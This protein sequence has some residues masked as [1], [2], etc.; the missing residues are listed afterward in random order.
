MI[1]AKLLLREKCFHL[2]PLLVS[3]GNIILFF[4]YPN[5][6]HKNC[7]TERTAVLVKTTMLSTTSKKGQ[8]EMLDLSLWGSIIHRR[9]AKKRGGSGEKRKMNHN[10]LLMSSSLLWETQIWAVMPQQGIFV[11]SSS[12]IWLIY[13]WDRDIVY[14]HTHYSTKLAVIPS[15][16]MGPGNIA[17]NATKK[18]THPFVWAPAHTCHLPGLVIII[19]MPVR[20]HTRGKGVGVRAC[21]HAGG[22]YVWVGVPPGTLF[23][24][25]VNSRRSPLQTGCLYTEVQGPVSCCAFMQLWPFWHK[26]ALTTGAAPS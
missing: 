24:K 4:S 17:E 9:P 10:V 19:I 21:V 8:G 6:R 2:I 26:C 16:A 3:R 14:P 1:V 23:V 11:C 25:L 22:L 20:W 13:S 7:I 18:P 5:R 15:Y 12:L